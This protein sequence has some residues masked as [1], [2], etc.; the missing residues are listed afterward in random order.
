MIILPAIDLYE[1]K[2]VRLR[3]GDYAQMTVYSNHPWMT[4]QEFKDCGAEWIHIVDLEGARDGVPKNLDIIS[5]IIRETGLHIEV[6]GGIRTIEV[7][8][9]YLNL[10]VNRV[11]LGTAAVASPGFVEACV[12]RFG[13]A[14]AVSVDMKDGKVATSGWT[15][16]SDQDA[17]SFCRVIE[18]WGVQT[19]ICTD[20]S[21]DGLLEGTNLELY[22]TLR[23][24]LTIHIIASGGITGLDEIRTLAERGVNGAILGK[25]IYAGEIKLTDAIRE[26]AV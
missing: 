2:A 7:A 11:I 4:A 25:A 9:Q 15:E 23:E 18:S 13:D 22:Q 6:G 10:G 19:L 17:I 16:V 3:Q 5:R 20:I 14:V 12:S 1:G 26:A 8:E 24:Q 21:K